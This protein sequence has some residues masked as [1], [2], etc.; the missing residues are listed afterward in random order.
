MVYTFDNILKNFK[1]IHN[2]KG[3]N[4]ID[5]KVVFSTHFVPGIVLI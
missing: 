3:A 4:K 2:V 1:I 5:F